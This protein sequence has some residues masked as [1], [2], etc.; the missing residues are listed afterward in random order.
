M[1]N[2]Y[3]R[4]V[5]DYKLDLPYEVLSRKVNQDWNWALEGREGFPDTSEL[6]RSAFA[7]NPHMKVFLALGCY[8]LATPYYAALYTLSHMGLDAAL[9]RSIQTAY[10]EAG[11]MMYID[12]PSLKQ[13][14][15]DVE[16]F[17]KFALKGD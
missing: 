4:S 11:H 16:R 14:G 12:V 3:A 5:L 15:A 10:Y 6:L 13:M 1:M 7:K 2:H 8:D 9:R 17:I